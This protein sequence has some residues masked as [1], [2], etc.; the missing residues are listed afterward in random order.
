[1]VDVGIENRVAGTEGDVSRGRE[2]LDDDKR[3]VSE[4]EGEKPIATRGCPGMTEAA[5]GLQTVQVR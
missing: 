4:N 3:C 2:H 1:M 5:K